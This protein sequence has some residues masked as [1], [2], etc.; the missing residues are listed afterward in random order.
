MYNYFSPEII[1]SLNGSEKSVFKYSYEQIKSVKDM[2]IQDLA[3]ACFVSKTTVVRMCQKLGFEGFTE[4]RYFLRTVLEK[5]S[6]KSQYVKGEIH[7]IRQYDYSSMFQIINYEQLKD[8][9]NKIRDKRIYLF[10]KGLSQLIC[11]YLL[12]QFS[13]LDLHVTLFE[14]SHLARNLGKKMTEDDVV[15]IISASGKTAQVVDMAQIVKNTRATLISLTGVGINPLSQM[16]DIT[17]FALSSDDKRV[18]FDNQSRVGFL[19][20][21]QALVDV[22]IEEI[23]N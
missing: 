3:D 8:V 2:K 12:I 15:I 16:A 18:D 1:E 11:N 23:M 10:G 17:L 20:V 5:E 21:V 14:N 4:F 6:K 7:R 19:M 13:L 9:A 22:M